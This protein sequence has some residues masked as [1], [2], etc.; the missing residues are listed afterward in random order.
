MS[1]ERVSAA[2][3]TSGTS[4]GTVQLILSGS[5]SMWMMVRGRVDEL[6]RLVGGIGG[7]QLRADRDHHVGRTEHGV[8]RVVRSVASDDTCRER[9]S[10]VHGALACGGRHDGDVE[11]L[12]EQPQFSLGLGEPDTVAGHENRARAGADEFSRATDHGVFR[13]R[14]ARLPAAC[15][16]AQLRR[17]LGPGE[18]AA[19]CAAVD[20][21]GDGTGFAR[22]GV[23]DRRLG[24]LHGLRPDRVPRMSA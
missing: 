7:W 19:Q 15:R 12:G 17:V 5:T 14:C 3:E 16:G 21:H 9:M 10:L 4:A 22:G 23:L 24:E 11:T 18:P 8:G 1:A 6:G 13:R 20:H 2:S